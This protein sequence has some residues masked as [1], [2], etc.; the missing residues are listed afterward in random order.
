M[1]VGPE[2]EIAAVIIDPGMQLIRAPYSN[3]EQTA[4]ADDATQLGQSQ[5][6]VI[7]GQMH[8]GAHRPTSIEATVPEG[9]LMAEAWTACKLN[10]TH[11]PTPTADRSTPV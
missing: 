6:D 3:L 7:A 4:Q 11:S 1:V 9:R 8:E 2:S 5:V 10:P